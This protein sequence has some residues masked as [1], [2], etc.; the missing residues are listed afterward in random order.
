MVICA[1]LLGSSECLAS[2]PDSHIPWTAECSCKSV[3]PYTF[4]RE[5]GC[6]TGLAGRTLKHYMILVQ[7]QGNVSS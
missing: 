4:S 1:G 6:E 2:K 3:G 5:V 7:D